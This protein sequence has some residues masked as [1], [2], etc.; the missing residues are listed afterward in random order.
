MGERR[1]GLRGRCKA[2]SLPHARPPYNQGIMIWVFASL[3]LVVAIAGLFSILLVKVAQAKRASTKPN[4]YYCG[5]QA[6]HLS[7]PNGLAD[8]LLTHWNCIPHR[9]EVCFHR[10][11]R[12]AVP[13]ADDDS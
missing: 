1:G 9:C 11:Y 8:W 5:S 3:A 2:G 13:D 6:M 4:C 10:Q 12:L 7:S